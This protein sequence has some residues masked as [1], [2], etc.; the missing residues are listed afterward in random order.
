MDWREGTAAVL[1]LVVASSAVPGSI[2]QSEVQLRDAAPVQVK[3]AQFIS[4][5]TSTAGDLVRFGI[6]DD[7]IVDGVVVIRRGTLA[8]GTILEASPVRLA[9]GGW[10][11]RH[12][13]RAGRLVFTVNETTS[14]DGQTIRLRPPAP[15]QGGIH[16][17]GPAA[18]RPPALLNWA[19]EGA[20]FDVRVDGE[21]VVKRPL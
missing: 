16:E 5:E 2:L 11:W 3:L 4:S 12:R 6:A 17:R 18:G 9:R 8:T 20:R 13:P 15:T 10:F 7:V 14:V 1:M 19:H 21:Y